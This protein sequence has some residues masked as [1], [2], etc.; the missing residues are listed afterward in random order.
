MLECGTYVKELDRLYCN[1][2]LTCCQADTGR[3][4]E[5]ERARTPVHPVWDEN[6]NSFNHPDLVMSALRLASAAFITYSNF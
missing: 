4:R 3:E 6:V 2:V 1:K 5:M